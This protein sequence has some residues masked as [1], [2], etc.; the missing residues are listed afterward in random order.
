MTL[1]EKAAQLEDWATAI[2]AVS[3]IASSMLPSTA[4]RDLTFR[5]TCPP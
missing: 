5:I 2:P 1:D 3:V 4:V